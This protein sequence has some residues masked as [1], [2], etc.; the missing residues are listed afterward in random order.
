MAAAITATAKGAT[1]NSYATLAEA[2]S[3]MDARTGAATWDAAADDDKNRA[4]IEATNRIEQHDFYGSPTASDQRLK[5]PRVGTYDADGRYWAQDT[6]PRVVQYAQFEVALALVNG[7]L[8]FKDSGLEGF[9]SVRVGPLAVEINHGREPG[10]LPKQALRY[11]RGLM[12]S[13]GGLNVRVV[14][15]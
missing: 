15:A 2:E 8:E 3:Y 11:L 4:L 13:A 6:V 1:S 7:D 12:V 14:R 5:W 10:A 9:D